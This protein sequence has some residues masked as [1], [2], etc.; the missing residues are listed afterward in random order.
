M[1]LEYR[2][3]L[4]D[5]LVL[6]KENARKSLAKMTWRAKTHFVSICRQFEELR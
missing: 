5:V 3:S 2:L 6:I 4:Q 1:K